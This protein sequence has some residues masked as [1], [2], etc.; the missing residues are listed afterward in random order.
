MIGIGLMVVGSNLPDA[1][2]LYSA[3]TGSK[4]DYLLQHR[5]YTHTVLGAVAFAALA[6]GCLALWLRSRHIPWS[7]S[8]ARYLFA[9][10]LLAPLLHIGLDFTNSY[11]VHPFWPVRNDWF[12]GDAVFIVE[13]L[14]WVAATPFLFTLRSTV[15]RILVGLALVAGIILSFASGLVPVVALGCAYCPRCPAR[16]D[17]KSL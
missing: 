3:L 14:L 4:L 15:A 13:P 2:F 7:S 10:A 11:G 16:R 8:D 17:R 9:M 1:D 5:G 6:L 12:Y